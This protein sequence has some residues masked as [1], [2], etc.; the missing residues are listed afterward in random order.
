VALLGKNT[1][2]TAIAF[3][4]KRLSDKLL[5]PNQSV[6][7]MLTAAI[8]ASDTAPKVL[9]EMFLESADGESL[10]AKRLISVI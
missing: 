9:V 7:H 3:D 6:N 10:R 1:H 4:D 2:Q 5:M 8:D